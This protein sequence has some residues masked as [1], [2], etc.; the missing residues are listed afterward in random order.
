M[1]VR[2]L[3]GVFAREQRD[4]KILRRMATKAM[5]SSY[6]FGVEQAPSNP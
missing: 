1:V 2:L 5:N 3:T 4:S 6:V